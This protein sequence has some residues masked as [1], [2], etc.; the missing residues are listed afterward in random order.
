MNCDFGLTGHLFAASEAADDPKIMT[1][2][3]RTKPNVF[4]TEKKHY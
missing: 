4:F 3:A 1:F 2:S